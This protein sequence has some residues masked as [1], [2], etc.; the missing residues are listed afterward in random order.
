MSASLKCDQCPHTSLHCTPNTK[1]E[2][3]P[4]CS[5]LEVLMSSHTA[6]H[7]PLLVTHR[8]TLTLHILHATGSCHSGR[9][10]LPAKTDML[11]PHVPM[12]CVLARSLGYVPF[13]LLSHSYI[14]VD[15]HFL[16]ALQLSHQL[17]PSP[18]CR[19]LALLLGVEGVGVLLGCRHS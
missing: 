5:E 4:Y 3:L 6:Y 9:P 16:H 8:V 15:L 2:C 18:L 14:L 7:T 17:T 1:T 13:T 11:H 10:K 19:V 12:P